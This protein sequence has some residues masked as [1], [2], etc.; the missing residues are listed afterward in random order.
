MGQESLCPLEP[1]GASRDD[2]LPTMREHKEDPVGYLENKLSVDYPGDAELMRVSIK[3]TRRDDL[4]KIVNSVVEAYMEEIVTSDKMARLKQR[5]LLNEHYSKSKVE[6]RD[7]ADKYH[8]LAKQLGANSSQTAQMR[9]KL[10]TMKLESLVEPQRSGA[11]AAEHELRVRLLNYGTEGR[12]RALPPCGDRYHHRGRVGQGSG[13]RGQREETRQSE[14]DHQEQ[15]YLVANP[16]HF[17]V[18]QAKPGRPLWKSKSPR[19]AAEVQ[20]Q[21]VERVAEAM[22]PR[23]NALGGA[24]P[25]LVL[26]RW[27]PRGKRW[28][29]MLRRPTRESYRP[30]TNSRNWT[31]RRPTWK[32]GRPSSTT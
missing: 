28:P 1:G 23:A 27:R 15:E 30:W 2:K 16:N 24:D 21:I 31:P 17:S 25:E 14:V 10:L 19:H 18:N 22:A 3:G 13:N 9:K 7:L 5:D 8:E 29:N 20:P 4:A 26:P 12:K 32:T 11:A 6:Y